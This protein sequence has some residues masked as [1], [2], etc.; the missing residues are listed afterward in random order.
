MHKSANCTNHSPNIFWN[1]IFCWQK[2]SR[3]LGNFLIL[4]C[5]SL[6]I[7]DKYVLLL[8]P[9]VIHSSR[10]VSNKFDN[11]CAHSGAVCDSKIWKCQYFAPSSYRLTFHWTW[12]NNCGKKYSFPL[13]LLLLKKYKKAEPCQL[14]WTG[15]QKICQTAGYHNY[16]KIV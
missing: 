9:F 13:L 2:M 4:H 1:S 11:F 8:Y 16:S 15:C 10:F 7:F 12:R 3:I 14:C 5:I 6:D